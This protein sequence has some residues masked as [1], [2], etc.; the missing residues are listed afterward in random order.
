MRLGHTASKVQVVLALGDSPSGAD[1][2]HVLVPTLQEN[3][4]QNFCLGDVNIPRQLPGGGN[5]TAMN[6]MNGTLMVI[7]GGDDP[8]EGGLYNCADITFTDTPLSQQDYNSH[9]TN[10]TGVRVSALPQEQ[11]G[12]NANG[13]MPGGATAP[14]AVTTSGPSDSASTASP[15]PGAGVILHPPVAGAMGV[16]VAVFVATSMGFGLMV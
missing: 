2:A 15:S 11:A 10:S 12:M 9:C 13:T 1:F 3:G 16:C 8:A 5:A 4:P 7:T 14:G 6:G